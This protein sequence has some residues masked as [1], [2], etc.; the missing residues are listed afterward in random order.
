MEMLRENFKC[1]LF[2]VRSGREHPKTLENIKE[3]FEEELLVK[4]IVK[5]KYEVC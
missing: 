5:K 3:K 4:V 1:Q 2:E